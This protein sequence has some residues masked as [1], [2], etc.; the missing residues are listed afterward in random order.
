MNTPG[1]AE[2]TWSWRLVDA[3]LQGPLPMLAILVSLAAGFIALQ[4]TPREE[5]PQIVVPL[6]DIHVSA[7]GL[8]APQVER[9]VATRL[10]KLLAQ[11]DGV[12]YVYSMSMPDR[13]IVTV[14]FFVG[15][16]RERSLVKIY[17]KLHSNTDAIPAEVAGWVVKPVEI[18]DVPI[19]VATLWSDAPSV[20]GPYE[21]RRVAEELEHELQAVPE[22]NRVTT[23]GGTPREVRV[24]LNP[25]ALASRRMAPLDVAYALQASNMARPAGRIDRDGASYVAEAGPF[26]RNARDLGQLV[27]NVVDGLPVYLHDVAEVVDGPA[28]AVT[29]SWIGFGP[30]GTSEA[31][32]LAEGALAPAVHLA[33]AKRRG[34]NAVSV[35]ED[36]L[37]RLEELRET[38]LPDGMR[39][40]VTRNQGLTAD[41]KV[42]ELVEGL[43]IAV[44]TVVVF[45]GLVLGFRAA[46]IIA[47]AIPVCYG[48]TLLLNYLAGY[49]INR[50][51]LFALTL[52]LGLLVD[53]PITDVE[54]IE[55]HYAKG[56]LPRRLATLT[57][58]QEVRPA[59]IMSTIAIVFSF[60]P[61]FYITGLMGPYM[62][63][64]AFNVPLTV[65]MSTVVAFIVTPWLA[66]K[67]LP[68]EAAGSEVEAI[69]ESWRFRLYG[70]L[71]RPLLR[72]PALAWGFLITVGVLFLAALALPLLRQVPLKMLPYDNKSEFQ[73]VVNMP[74]GTGLETTDGLL[75]DLAAY[76]LR[77]PEVRDVTLFAGESSPVDFNGLIRH[78]YLRQGP[79]VGDLRVN[80][81]PKAARERSSHAMVMALRGPL[82]E[83]ASARGAKLQL[84]EAPPGPPVI[85]T[86]AAE[87][88]GDP[89]T[90]YAE[91]ERGAE[92]LAERLRREPG[93]VDVDTSVEA[94]PPKLVFT[95]D[96][97]KAAL[98]AVATD[99]V[100]RT[101]ALAIQ[102]LP[103]G[104]LEDPT[105]VN[106][107]RP[108][109]RLPRTLRA[110]PAALAALHVLGRPGYTRV[111]EGAALADAPRPLVA[112]GE[113][114]QWEMVPTTSTIYHKNL[115]PVA[116]VFADV[117]GRPPAEAILDVIA[118]ETGAT[119]AGHL[120]RSSESRQVGGRTYLARGGG[121]AWSMPEGTRA[122]WTGEGEWKI[123]LDAFR[124]LGIAFAAANIAIFFVLWL[125]VGSVPI[126]LI[127]MAAI[128]L[129]MIGVLPGFQML[130]LLG[131][132]GAVPD[133]TFFTA[134]AM[135]G[136]IALSGIVVRNSLVLV[137]F[138]HHSLRDGKTLDEALVL[139]GATRFRA[140]LLTAGT[141]LLGNV[142]ITLDPIFSGLAWSIMFGLLASTVFTLFVVPVI[143]HR[144]YAHRPGHGLAVATTQNSNK[145]VAHHE[146]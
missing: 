50:V 117:A 64:M 138:V 93:V 106:A 63:P 51:T 19:V 129:T 30:A 7:P 17:N 96:R 74:E 137:D 32:G 102:G 34:T 120:D 10:E 23:V 128:P 90:S 20:I 143:Y 83:I 29:T 79:H 12:E 98:S 16:D 84:T 78:H 47:L 95:T 45:I 135:I 9:Q 76:L 71:L 119:G 42:D 124:D 107:L 82:E 13:A 33:I 57:A 121:V 60:L 75:R 68:R 101:I 130:N 99:D 27:V 116:Y 62:A 6:A 103:L 26:I 134:T 118:D 70:L 58:V 15:E 46:L 28:E 44:V 36:T 131:G 24:E 1:G 113:L 2:R 77:V 25:E 125:E 133:P 48:A 91:L 88:M 115:K 126:T 55:R 40:T 109:L 39:L 145:E 142:V 52:A 37:Q 54:N 21:L 114:G 140:I 86:I 104:M 80:L 18:D 53:D 112:L 139:A 4:V 97:E 132:G 41:E 110:D 123:T 31:A 87:V 61:L 11:I 141:T 81:V 144:V 73:V 3:L 100:V 59:L 38:H 111:R 85:A 105:E 14:R 56:K 94:R 89:G 22:T 122:V 43:A 136:L 49:S 69:E 65:I 5:E 108:V 72:R 66:Y 92:L 127:L 35:A 8:D 146:Q 67:L